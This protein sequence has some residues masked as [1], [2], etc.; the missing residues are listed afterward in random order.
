MLRLR[1]H[2]FPWAHRISLINLDI[3]SDLFVIW[4][5][6]KWDGKIRGFLIEKVHL[7]VGS[8][9]AGNAYS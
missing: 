1:E 3:L 7:L 2:S 9:Q 4:A 6:C 8:L 5:R